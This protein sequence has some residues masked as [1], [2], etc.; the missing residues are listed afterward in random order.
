MNEK[1]KISMLCLVVVFT[2]CSVVACSEDDDV[3]SEVNTDDTNLD[4]NNT[5]EKD[6]EDTNSEEGDTSEDPLGTITVS[7]TVKRAPSATLTGDGIGTICVA[8]TLSCPS[9]SNPNP[10]TL[11]D[12]GVA[13]KNA[14]V[15][16][17]D[18][19]VPYDIA[20]DTSTA[21]MG[22]SYFLTAVMKE[23]GSECAPVPGEPT[24]RAG[25]LVAMTCGRFDFDGTDVED[26]ELILDWTLTSDM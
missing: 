4:G 15:S 16:V 18:N 14:D 20:V 22:K 24:L 6:N 9:G 17:A 8:I 26:L 21:E 10:E 5:G 25:D 11:G 23:D 13:L 1:F 12:A 19:S 7:G 3:D 2:F